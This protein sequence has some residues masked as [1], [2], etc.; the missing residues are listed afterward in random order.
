[1]IT[2]S[3]RRR[4]SKR[5]RPAVL[6]WPIA[7]KAVGPKIHW[8]EAMYRQIIWCSIKAITVSLSWFRRV[9]GQ[10]SLDLRMAGSVAFIDR[11]VY[12]SRPIQ[13]SFALVKVGSLKNVDVSYSNLSEGRTNAKG[14][15]LVPDLIAYD[16]NQLSI[17]DTDVAVNYNLTDVRKLVTPWFRG[18]TVAGLMLRKSKDSW[19]MCLSEKRGNRSPLNMGTWCFLYP[20]SLRS[21][22]WWGR[23]ANFM[24]RIS[25]QGTFPFVLNG[26]KRPASSK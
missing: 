25:S 2:H 19:D 22:Q 20:I 13:D 24:W 14:E 8:P 11:G 23:V 18:G 4:L 26:N 5:I 17:K 10:D 21:R 7:F 3:A 15:L 12:F 6:D 9:Q 16:E 1:M